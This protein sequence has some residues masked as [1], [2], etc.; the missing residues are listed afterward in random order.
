M[1]WPTERLVMIHWI[2]SAGRSGWERDEDTITEASHIYTIGW[3]ISE[4]D[5]S[6][7]ITGH[8]V[9]QE[10]QRQSHGP[11]CDP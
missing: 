5:E 2:D 10:H 8:R 11:T 7:C 1:S 3:M 4:S 6:L 9:T